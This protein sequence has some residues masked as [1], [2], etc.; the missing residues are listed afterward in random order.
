M[1]QCSDCVFTGINNLIDRLNSDNES[2]I[3]SLLEH[4][5]SLHTEDCDCAINEILKEDVNER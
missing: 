3:L 1:S 4:H 5:L 2:L